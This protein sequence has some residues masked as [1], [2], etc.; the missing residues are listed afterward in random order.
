MKDYSESHHKLFG[1]RCLTADGG[2][3][4]FACELAKPRVPYF[5]PKIRWWE[6]DPRYRLAVRCG[7]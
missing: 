4:F 3:C 2:V 6:S 5:F 7:P 1:I